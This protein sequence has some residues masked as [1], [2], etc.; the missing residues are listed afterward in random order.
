[1]SFDIFIA[2]L[3]Y[4]TPA[5]LISEAGLPLALCFIILW[6]IL[7]GV[8]LLERLTDK[9]YTATF[10]EI[11]G[12]SSLLALAATLLMAGLAFV[13]STETNISNIA[14][15]KE[16]IQQEYGF[17]LTDE[18]VETLHETRGNASKD[19]LYVVDVD[20][21]LHPYVI[22]GSEFHF[23]DAHGNELK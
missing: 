1:M 15:V 23:V 14:E 22:V 18:S 21:Q 17:E 9:R 4:P 19:H 8:A 12:L 10:K 5:E 7:V 2:E 13:S 11:A 16:T 6:A 20:G 3:V